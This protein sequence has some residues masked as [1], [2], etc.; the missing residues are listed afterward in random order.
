MN[1]F[2]D[3]VIIVDAHTLTV[4]RLVLL[5]M[6]QVPSVANSTLITCVLFI[7]IQYND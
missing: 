5:E 6:L 3:N 4:T 1:S 7:I 2:T